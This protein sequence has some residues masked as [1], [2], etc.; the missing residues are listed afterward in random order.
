MRARHGDISCSERLDDSKFALDRMGRRKQSAGRLLAHHEARVAS[1]EQKRRVRLAAN[2]LAHAEWAM[3]IRHVVAQIML[4]P[5]LIESMIL[6]HSRDA[7]V[8][9]CFS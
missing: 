3:E 1:L 2:E 4:E 7:N 9:F 6:A 8:Q 5:G